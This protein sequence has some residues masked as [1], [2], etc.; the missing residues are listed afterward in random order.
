M[1]PNEFLQPM[2]IGELLD[3]TIKLFRKRFFKFIAIT[4]IGYIPFIIIAILFGVFAA[5]STIALS[6][7]PNPNPFSNIPPSLWGIMVLLTIVGSLVYG[8]TR[9]GLIKACQEVI[10]E[11]QITM[12]KCFKTGLRKLF[13]YIVAGILVFFAVFFGFILLIIPGIIFSVWFS[14]F[15][16]VTVLEDS[17]YARALGRSKFLVKGYFWR[18]LGFFIVTGLLSF[19][20][21]GILS[22]ILGLIPIVGQLISLLLQLIIIPFQ[23]IAETLYYYNQRAVKEGLDLSLASEDVLTPEGDA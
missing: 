7:P 3:K 8:I 23:V 9:L 2:G 22:Q 5:V 18:T 16:P 13:P 11:D 17:G 14:V 15:E 10:F 12:G 19:A 21:V 1:I 4:A 20:V 6:T